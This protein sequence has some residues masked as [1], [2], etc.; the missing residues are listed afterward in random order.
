MK[1]RSTIFPLTVTTGDLVIPFMPIGFAGIN[2]QGTVVATRSVH[3]KMLD[4]AVR[5]HITPIIEKFPLTKNGIEEGMTRVREGKMRY[6]GV[7]V[8]V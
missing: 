3:K 1:P 2:I 7:L 6:K 5:N 8:A 4:F